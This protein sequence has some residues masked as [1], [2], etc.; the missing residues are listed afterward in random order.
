MEKYIIFFYKTSSDKEI[1][2]E[3]IEK[4]DDQTG[5]K[6]KNGINLLR[7]YG[8]T[9]INTPWIKKINKKYSIY[10]LRIKTNLTIRLLFFFLKPKTFVIVHIFTSYCCGF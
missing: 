9:L 3:F 5:A 10:E 2:M 6:V 7:L 4:L 8:L 1:I